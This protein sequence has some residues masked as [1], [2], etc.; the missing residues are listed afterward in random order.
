MGKFGY[1]ME[2]VAF[3]CKRQNDTAK[4]GAYSGEQRLMVF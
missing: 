3:G 2:S 4:P 1:D